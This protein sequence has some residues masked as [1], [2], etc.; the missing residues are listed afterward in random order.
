M[1]VQKRN[2]D[3]EGA[4]LLKCPLGVV[5]SLPVL[6]GHKE[7][8]QTQGWVQGQHVPDGEEAAALTRS[9]QMAVHWQRKSQHAPHLPSDFD[10]F[11]LSTAGSR[12][13]V[14]AGREQP[15]SGC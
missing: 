11:S 1:L 14:R 9:A 2:T 10:I 12:S 8:A 5:D 6:R 4:Y 15:Q 13:R 7:Q 3:R